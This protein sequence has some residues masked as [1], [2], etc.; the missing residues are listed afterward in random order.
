MF[1][2]GSSWLA[3]L[4]AV[5]APALAQPREPGA[6]TPIVVSGQPTLSEEQARTLVRRVARP[7]DGQLARFDEPICPEVNGF[8]AE[9]AALVGAWIK[10]TAERVGLEAGG[11]DCTANLFL[12]IVD[13]APAFVE[14][15]ARRDPA[16]VTGL[17]RREFEQLSGVAGPARSWSTTLVTNGLG[18]SAGR[19][20][21]SRGH[22]AV[23]TGFAGSSVSFGDV[24]VMRI[25]DASNANP[26]VQQTIR[27]SW[28][29]LETQATLGKSLRQIADYA[30]MRGLAMV[31]PETLDSGA[32]SILGL[33]EAGEPS[34][35]P[36]LTEFDLA[37]L[38]SLYRV[39][40][41]RWARSQVHYIANAIARNSGEDT[42]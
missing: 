22:G 41:R 28:V 29:V 3:V 32:V 37:Y 1:R 13:D 10:A 19:P 18:G 38:T 39:P 20:S 7:V 33:F 2:R 31:R 5:A 42:P 36:A 9:Y 17:S 40:A 27:S 4:G 21:P 24:P 12:V 35:P 23:K 14:E 25:Y 34:A 8:E 30:A 11:D 26:S 15:L 6:D 16:A